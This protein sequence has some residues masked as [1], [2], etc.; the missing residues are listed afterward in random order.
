VLIDWGA[1]EF[2]RLARSWV[3]KG[4]L[5]P[6]PLLVP[7]AAWAIAAGLHGRGPQVSGR[8]VVWA[9]WLLTVAVGCV[10]LWGRAVVGESL[11]ALA[12]LGFGTPYFALPIAALYWLHQAD[13]WL[14]FLLCA[15]V[16]LGDSAGFYVGSLFGRHKLAPVVSPNKSWEGAAASFA[17]AL[18]ATAVWSW[19]RLD[20][21]DGALLLV[22]AATSIAAQCGDLVESM[23]KR[24][25]GVKDSGGV[26]PGHGGMY[27]R[28]DAMLFG[29]PTF[30][31]GLWWTGFPGI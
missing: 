28:M 6:L 19:Y 30:L 9:L 4:P 5:A 31:A 12:V 20:R 2:V 14:L 15:I 24:G 18:V 10:V 13:S 16:W 29:A 22:A 27:D 23:L 8:G 11:P 25:A 3:P 1:V 17:T 26:L 7:V 21:V